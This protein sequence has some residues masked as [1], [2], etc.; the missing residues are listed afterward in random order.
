MTC[1]TF[2]L[3][4]LVF[5]FLMELAANRNLLLCTFNQ[6][7]YHPRDKTISFKLSVRQ[8]RKKHLYPGRAGHLDMSPYATI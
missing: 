8:Q 7:K 5:V 4:L 6:I 2:A 1:E 3:I